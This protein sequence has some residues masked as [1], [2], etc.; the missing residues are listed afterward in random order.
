MG[1]E[2]IIADEKKQILEYLDIA[3]KYSKASDYE[4]TFEVLEK[5]LYKAESLEDSNLKAKIHNNIGNTRSLI[6]DYEKAL[7][8]YMIALR[9][10]EEK[11]EARGIGGTLLNIGVLYLNQ[12]YFNEALEYFNNSLEVYK[13]IDD[14]QGICFAT[15]NIGIIYLEL[16]EHEKAK[17]M[18]EESGKMARDLE[19]RVQI[20]TCYTN[21]GT[22]ET[23]LTN[24]NKAL[25]YYEQALDIEN[26]LQCKRTL[27]NVLYS[28]AEVYFFIA[29]YIDMLYFLEKA[30]K[31]AKEDK[32]KLL[33][34]DC[35]KLYYTYFEKVKDYKE[36][37]KYHKIYSSLN[38]TIFNENRNEITAELKI[39]YDIYK[40]E[41]EKEIYKLKN[42]E[43][44][45]LNEKLGIAYKELEIL[46]NTD[47]LTK[48]YNRKAIT[49]IM[50]KE[51]Y[52]NKSISPFIICI[53]DIDDFKKVNDTYGHEAGD[54]VLCSCSNALTKHLRKSD[55]VARWGG[56]EFLI[57]LPNTNLDDGNR[58]IEKLRKTIAQGQ[59]LY[60]EQVI[61][62]TMTFGVAC[63]YGEHQLKECI[64]LADRYLY[65]GKSNG[66]NC[67][68][69]N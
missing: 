13:G 43:L 32:D 29:N 7:E 17:S 25:E 67:V 28:I 2:T 4:K 66:K 45:E 52:H 36:A 16:Q 24:F 8:Q 3:N 38:E 54:E 39:K 26:Q 63:F 49:E 34:L 61:K 18:F 5:A 69:S 1:K 12:N 51:L 21:L 53:A 57:I 37:L 50:E 11:N 68:C 9:L 58:V 41:K 20:A 60:N 23:K 48:I 40:E 56:E 30:L 19:D 65:K 46:H 55:Y 64:E 15:N 33:Q 31:N 22:V 6:G 10:C 35:Y 44:M 14:K 47:Y 62:V 59:V 27:S 42:I